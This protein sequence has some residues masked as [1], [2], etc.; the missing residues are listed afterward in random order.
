MIPDFTTQ[1]GCRDA[2]YTGSL[3]A[4]K[5]QADAQKELLR[6]GGPTGRTPGWGREADGKK[7]VRRKESSESK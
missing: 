2:C 3:E 6:V 4:L 5:G 7:L 1:L